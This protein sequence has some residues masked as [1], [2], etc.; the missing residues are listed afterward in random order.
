VIAKTRGLQVLEDSGVPHRAHTYQ[1]AE[2]EPS[3]GEA[4]AQALG[5]D[6][7]R[8]F[9]TLI[10]AVD[11]APVVGIVPVSGQ[12]SLKGLA[13]AAGA[14]KAEMV[15]A[16]DAERLTGYVIGRISPFGQKRR[17]P[18][19]IDGSAEGFETIYVSA[20]MRGLQVELG[21]DDLIRVLAATSAPIAG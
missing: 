6:P 11:G 8:V 5:V 10:A 14:K 9:K 3:Y 18:T 12:L 19:Y 13:A 17:L 4:V 16:A 15:S 21:P 20:G 1:P 2:T 7:L